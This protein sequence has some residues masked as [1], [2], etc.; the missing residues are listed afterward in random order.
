ML[1]DNVKKFTTENHQGVLTCFRRNGMPQMSIVTCGPY[2]ECVALT[3]TARRA[4][5]LNLQRNP[6]CS[7]MVSQEDWRGYVVLEGHAELLAPG[8]S[9]AAELR[10]ALRDVYR[11][12]SATEHPNW[13]G[14]E[15][16]WWDQGR[17]PEKLVLNPFSGTWAG[18]RPQPLGPGGS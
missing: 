15:A 11:A 3:T 12:A 16:D 7:L 4:K 1:S 10:E 18:S 6:R 13:G 2:R 17:P 9:D 8:I 5:L 14:S